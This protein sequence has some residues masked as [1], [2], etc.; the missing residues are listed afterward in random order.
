MR[1]RVKQLV[2]EFISETFTSAASSITVNGIDGTSLITNTDSND[3]NSNGIFALPTE[4]VEYEPYDRQL[5]ARVTSL[6]AQL[7]SL[8]TAVAQLRRDAPAR[9]AKEYGEQLSRALVADDEES[10]NIQE[11]AAGEEETELHVPLGSAQEAV[12]WREGDIAAVYEQTLRTMLH[13]QGEK[14]EEEE[15]YGNDEDALDS[16]ND[17]GGDGLATTVGKAERAGRAAEVVEHM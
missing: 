13:L 15:G 10:H 16:D 6:Y 14:V 1:E 5:A 3:N 8:T 9:A 7:E 4:T 17:S 2:D 12:R 11:D